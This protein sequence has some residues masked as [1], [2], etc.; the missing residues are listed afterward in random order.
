LRVL[1]GKSGDVVASARRYITEKY[2]TYPSMRLP[3]DVEIPTEMVADLIATIEDLQ[4]AIDDFNKSA[5]LLA[6]LSKI[7]DS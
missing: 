4:R 2:K 3:K 5:Q 1:D 6:S 7:E